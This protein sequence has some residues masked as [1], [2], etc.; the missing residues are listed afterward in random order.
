MAA[1]LPWLVGKSSWG[2]SH[3][4]PTFPNALP[5]VK[6]QVMDKETQK[7]V[8]VKAHFPRSMALAHQKLQPEE[9]NAQNLWWFMV[10]QAYTLIFHMS[11]K[12]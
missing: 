10:I 9:S 7:K 5:K 2:S 12:I 11:E 3:G 4:F 8:T 6:K 1:N